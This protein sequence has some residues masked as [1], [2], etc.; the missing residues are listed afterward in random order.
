[1]GAA[2]ELVRQLHAIHGLDPVEEARGIPCLVRLERADE[3]PRHRAAEGFDLLLG[4]LDA[5]LSKGRDACLDGEPDALELH[6]LGHADE[7]DVARP[8]VRSRAGG[9][10]PLLYRSKIGANVE[11]EDLSGWPILARAGSALPGELTE[12]RQGRTAKARVWR[13]AEGPQS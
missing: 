2:V 1:M 8:A 4:F 11:H 9:G 5:I 3:M 7:E 6:G 12:G 10:D 13:S